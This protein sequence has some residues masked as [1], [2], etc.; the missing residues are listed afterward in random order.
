MKKFLA[1]L[2]MFLLLG[3][4]SSI[5]L[6]Q[7]RIFRGSQGQLTDV[8]GVQAE[9][10]G[11]LPKP[12]L[13]GGDNGTD[14]TN[15]LV[16]LQGH[17]QVDV[18]STALPTGAA[19]AANQVLEIALLTTIDADTSALFGTVAGS[20]QQVD[21][22]TSALP[23]GAA[24]EA[25][26][27]GLNSKIPSLGAALIA[28]SQPVNIASDQVVPISATS[29]P[30]PT[31]AATEVTLADIAD[32][33][34]SDILDALTGHEGDFQAVF[35]TPLAFN[36]DSVAGATAGGIAA[37]VLRDD[38]LTTLTPIDG[39]YVRLR[40][41]S[42]GQLH[43]TGGTA[44]PLV[45]GAGT[46]A[47]AQRV[48]I[49][50]DSTGVLSVDDNGGSLTVDGTFFQATQP[51]SAVSLP[52]PTGA[53]TD[54]T[55]YAEDSIAMNLDIGQYVLGVSNQALTLL[56]ADG[57]YSSFATDRVGRALNIPM[58]NS[59]I[60][61]RFQLGKEED[62]V[63]TTADVGIMALAIRNDNLATAFANN[64]NY[65]GIAVDANG[66]VYKAPAGNNFFSIKDTAIAAVSQNFSFGFTSNKVI[67][68]TDSANGDEVCIDWA[69][70]TAVCPAADTA[71][72]DRVG[73]GRAIVLDDFAV[74]SI[75]VIS[76]S[77][78]NT[79]T[80]RAWN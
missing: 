35:G 18:L 61:D 30:L 24:T 76:S 44:A 74:S 19:T 46:E 66:G 29:L 12:I 80:V 15:I 64:G 38:V 49:A 5:A 27:S 72:D 20:E 57:D 39:D 1:V 50:T 25:T 47:L 11:T 73:S 2:S 23:T 48:T 13:I 40:V 31:G 22:V 9:G 69:G 3:S 78:T 21:V 52:L 79:I 6:G 33:L 4:Q 16:D 43:T 71:G 68:E 36:V 55:E 54:N 8:E 17:L 77:G 67:I 10:S 7:T 60:A 62:T 75:S 70:G 42:T 14:I 59:S 63:H 37:L 45:F 32:V 51:I 41:N 58:F 65:S 34:S 26:L 28:S 53:A 56:V